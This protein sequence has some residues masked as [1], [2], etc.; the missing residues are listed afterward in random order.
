LAVYN[1]FLFV[2]LKLEMY[3]GKTLVPSGLAPIVGGSAF[4][5]AELVTPVWVSFRTP[6]IKVRTMIW[7]NQQHQHY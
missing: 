3:P 7:L 1:A 2:I 5:L 6:L 4:P